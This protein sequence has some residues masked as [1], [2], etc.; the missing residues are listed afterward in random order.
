M[1]LIELINQPW[2]TCE[3]VIDQ[4]RY[5]VHLGANYH[6]LPT[7][8][9]NWATYSHILSVSIYSVNVTITHVTREQPF[10][11][12]LVPFVRPL[13]SLFWKS[14]DVCYGFRSHGKSLAGVLRLLRDPEIHLWCNTCYPVDC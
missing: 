10:W 14:R 9:L 2:S 1:D 8:L 12:V 11:R 3:Q 7:N 5:G 6:C 13:V 4:V